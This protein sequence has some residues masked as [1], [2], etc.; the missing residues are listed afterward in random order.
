MKQ[1]CL[2]RVNQQDQ[3]RKRLSCGLCQRAEAR[4]RN[5]S[6]R[7][8]TLVELIAV[9]GCLSVIMGVAVVLLFQMFDMQRRNEERSVEIRSTNRF[10]VV[11][12]ED[13]HRLG[14]PEIK[15]NSIDQEKVL[16]SW[17]SDDSIV[18]Y[19]LQDGD[20]PGQKFVR[21]IEKTDEKVRKIDDYR[22]PDQSVLRFYDGKDD[23]AD[24][25]ALSL[26]RQTPG[27]NVPKADEMN[28]FNRTLPAVSLDETV[29]VGIWRTVLARFNN[30]KENR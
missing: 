28:P 13:V 29:H 18:Q 14:K 4:I 6:Y 1:A 22:L 24:L 19:E 12:R 27:M 8:F 11:F 15:A 23:H 3:E 26:W 20:F 17:Q 2:F 21:R 10:V 25:V 16:L 30:M 7:G 9:I 5:R